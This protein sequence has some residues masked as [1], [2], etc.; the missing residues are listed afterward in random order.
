M[1]SYLLS[2]VA[3]LVGIA[4]LLLLFDK[5]EFLQLRYEGDEKVLVIG[6]VSNSSFVTVFDFWRLMVALFDR[7]GRPF[8][9]APH[10]RVVSIL[11][12]AYLFP[13]FLPQ[14]PPSSYYTL[15]PSLLLPNLGLSFSAKSSPQSSDAQYLDSSPSPVRLNTVSTSPLSMLTEEPSF[16]SLELWQLR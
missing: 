3:S 13:P 6:S 11:L 5:T 10:R 12:R 8:F 16:G 2:F 14:V 4:S 7:W 9:F 1:E 15:Y